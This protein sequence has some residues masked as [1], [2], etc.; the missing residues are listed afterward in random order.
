MTLHE[1]TKSLSHLAFELGVELDPRS[2]RAYHVA[3]GDVQAALLE[4]ACHTVTVTPPNR[5]EPRFPPPAKLRR[6]CEEA[7]VK[8]SQAL[9][10]T[11]CEACADQHGWVPIII[12]GVSRL[13]RCDCW[14]AHQARIAAGG[15]S[16]P[17]ALPAAEEVEA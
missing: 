17:L 13:T 8:A 1:C 10:W 7:R 16:T 9:T 11:P 5:Y 15:L 3:L 6:L 2:I 14:H 12:D 4:S